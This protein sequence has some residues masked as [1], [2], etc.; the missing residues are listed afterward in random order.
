MATLTLE[1]PDSLAQRIQPLSRWLPTILE[2]NLL[3]LQTPASQT[4]KEIIDF[5]ASNPSTK[6]VHHYY[7]SE[8]AQARMSELL[9]LNRESLIT[10]DEL[11]ELDELIALAS[12]ITT[13][14][15]SLT[16]TEIA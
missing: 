3:P 7:A 16:N 13:L 1:L 12:L 4:A 5:L 11:A 15:A 2:I 10:S 9:D 6:T 8:K 14:K